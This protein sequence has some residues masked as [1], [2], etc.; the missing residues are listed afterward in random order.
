MK[1]K[2]IVLLLWMC[3]PLW[4]LGQSKTLTVENFKKVIVSPHIEVE[5]KKGTKESVEI[6]ENHS[7]L[8]IDVKGKTLHLYLNDAKIT[9][10]TKKMKVNGY[11][12]KVPIYKGRLVKAVITYKEVE[13]FALRGEEDFYFAS[14]LEQDKLTLTV[15]GEPEVV[16]E[17]VQ[18]NK[19]KTTLYGAS[20]FTIKK[21]SV[22]EQKYTV[23]GEARIKVAEVKSSQTKIVAHGSANVKINVSDRLKVTSYG[24]TKVYYRGSPKV[25]KGIVIGDTLIEAL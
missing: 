16:I 11:M 23:Y 7:A 1:T 8:N 14:A 10:P 3:T 17:K 5:F 18:V 4:L 13:T 21:G 25:S 22:K 12:Q 24:E 15:Y 20:K 6:I 9:S 2:Y 19:M